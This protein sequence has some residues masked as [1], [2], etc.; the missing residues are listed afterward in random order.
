MFSGFKPTNFTV[1]LYVQME[2]LIVSKEKELGIDLGFFG[3]GV[4]LLEK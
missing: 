1:G 3:F 2:E 4:N